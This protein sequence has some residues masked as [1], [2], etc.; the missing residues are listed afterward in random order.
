[1]LKIFSTLTGILLLSSIVFVTLAP[2][3]GEKSAR[4]ICFKKCSEQ[5][6]KCVDKPGMTRIA[7][8]KQHQECIQICTELLAE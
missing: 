6:D 7:C 3:A 2:A 8:A 4:D 1:M 5:M